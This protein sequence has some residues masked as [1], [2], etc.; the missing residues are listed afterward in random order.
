M[1]YPLMCLLLNKY[2]LKPINSFLLSK[3]LQ[4]AIFSATGY[5]HRCITVQRQSAT[6]I[7]RPQ[8]SCEGYV[9]TP[10]CQSFCS[11]GGGGVAIPACIAGGI[12][13]CLAKGGSAP[14]GGAWSSGGMPG[15]GGGEWNCDLSVYE[16]S[17]ISRNERWLPWIGNK[18]LGCFTVQLISGSVCKSLVLT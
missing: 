4:L 10:V 15:R 6:H 3:E 18:L 9:I 8:R 17:F 1:N 16:F 14:W 13:A 12:P 11:R 5:S 2:L 7:Y